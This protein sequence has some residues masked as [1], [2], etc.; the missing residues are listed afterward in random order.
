MDLL[1]TEL[2]GLASVTILALVLSWLYF[3]PMK[4]LD[5]LRVSK[6]VEVLGRD[7]IMNA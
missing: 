2:L 4:R 6:S 1:G 5:Y 3:F 7:T